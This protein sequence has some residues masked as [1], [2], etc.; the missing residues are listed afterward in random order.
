[1]TLDLWHPNCWAVESTD[2]TGGGVLAHAV[3]NSPTT[4]GSPETVRGLFTSF[5]DTSAEVEQLLDAIRDSD[6][7]GEVFE[8][9]ERF[10]RA[11]NAPG[12]VVREFFLEYDP[13]EMVCP[14]LLEHGFVHSAPVRIEDGSEEWNLCFAGDRSAIDDSLDDV[15]EQ[16]GAEVTVTSITTSEEPERSTR[17]ERLDTLTIAQREVFD[18]ARETGYY[19][20]P[21]ETTTRELADDMDLAKS[22]LLEHLRRAE[23]KLLDP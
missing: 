5:G 22:T 21:R 9:Q 10:G 19:E 16:T 23:S 2:R 18:H 13:S 4:D 14:T 6:H 11:R 12:N 7:S 17:N 20:W 8:L 3:Y 1:M 15:R